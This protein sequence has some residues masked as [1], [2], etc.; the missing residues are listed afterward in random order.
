MTQF[1]KDKAMQ[2]KIIKLSE[3]QAEYRNEIP[4][5]EWIG[6]IPGVANGWQIEYSKGGAFEYGSVTFQF[7]MIEADVARYE[8]Y[9]GSWL[10]EIPRMNGWEPT[11][12]VVFRGY[13][14]EHYDFD[15]RDYYYEDYDPAV[16][17]AYIVGH[18][19]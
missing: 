14:T 15:E 4:D 6:I 13:Y 5:S 11:G 3:S 9:C 1:E 17:R 8:G 18:T 7:G 19:D 16:E 10:F 2:F 12:R